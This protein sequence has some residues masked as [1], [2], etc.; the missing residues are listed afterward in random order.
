VEVLLVLGAAAAISG[1][2]MWG[3]KRGL[4]FAESVRV[5]FGAT[6]PSPGW[7]EPHIA[8]LLTSTAGGIRPP[9]RDAPADHRRAI[10]QLAAT[11]PVSNAVLGNAATDMAKR[12]LAAIEECDAQVS[13]LAHVAT[14]SELDRL[15]A[16]LATLGE[17]SEG[18]RAARGELQELVRRQLDIVRRMRD[19]S[20]VVSQRRA[21]LF[22][23]LRGLWTQL[24]IVRDGTVDER[25]SA[26]RFSALLAESAAD[27]EATVSAPATA[28]GRV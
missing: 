3:V 17:G 9:E 19:Q 27:V 7:N 26:E 14:A 13:S 23:L 2:L 15:T 1:C 18:D 21:R 28:R 16:Q 22:T 12:L 10:E 25:A 8:R 4:S 11:L 6:M 24:N 5:L 20:E